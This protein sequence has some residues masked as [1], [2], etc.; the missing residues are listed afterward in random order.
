MS[1]ILNMRL[2]E[3]F[4][5]TLA[6]AAREKILYDFDIDAGCKIFEDALGCSREQALQMIDGS[7]YALYVADDGVNVMMCEREELPSG[8]TYEAF[9]AKSH[10][11]LWKK[12]IVREAREIIKSFQRIYNTLS[13]PNKRVWLTFPVDVKAEDII[14]AIVNERPEDL[15]DHL[16][17]KLL[18]YIGSEHDKD[19]SK[20]GRL[21]SHLKFA[22]SWM[23]DASAKIRTIQDMK[24]NG[25]L[26]IGDTKCSEYLEDAPNYVTEVFDVSNSI[27]I[28]TKTYSPEESFNSLLDE[29]FEAEKKIRT[30]LK[31]TIWPADI[32]KKY[33]AGWLSPKG[34]YFGLN[35]TVANMLHIQLADKLYEQ[36]FIPQNDETKELLQK[37][38]WLEENGWV[39]IHDNEIGFWPTD[40]MREPTDLQLKKLIE[41]ARAHY[42]GN[43]K[44]TS[45]GKTIK[46]SVLESAEKLQV[47][48]LFNAGKFLY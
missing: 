21:A 27:I 23:E 9:D 10:T 25:L 46:A 34:Q 36:G 33:D 39:R 20:I 1:K 6:Q 18:D 2:G 24:V 19:L 3:N 13:S 26:H 41:Y 16:Y 44:N 30:E 4:C 37:D 35:G 48:E 45:N 43:L 12:Q 40:N 14:E 42:R 7:K 22:L 17:N 28:R 47:R 31:Y 8:K 29:Y 5:E 11:D 32:T 38:T 15:K